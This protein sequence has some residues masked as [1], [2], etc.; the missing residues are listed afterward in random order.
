MENTERQRLI[1]AW[2]LFHSQRHPW[3]HE[4]DD[5]DP[6]DLSQFEVAHCYPWQAEALH[7]A[8]KPV[9]ALCGVKLDPNK[10]VKRDV[11]AEKCPK[12]LAKTPTKD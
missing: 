4:P 11:N 7:S 1:E 6:R 12:C 9:A 5:P 2:D 3:M 10:P 8:G